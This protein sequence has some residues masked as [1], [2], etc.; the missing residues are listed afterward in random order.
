MKSFKY[1]LLLLFSTVWLLSA[2]TSHY[3]LSEGIKRFYLHS[4]NSIGFACTGD[5][6]NCGI[7][8]VLSDT[9]I[10]DKSY[11][12]VKWEWQHIHNEEY[13]F[14]TEKNYFRIDQGI[15]YRYS[16][17][18]DEFVQD[19]NFSK[20]DSLAK[21]FN[22]IEWQTG[23]PPEI[24]VYDTLATFSDGSTHRVLW[25]DNDSIFIPNHG[26]LNEQLPTCKGF[27]DSVLVISDNN[28]ILPTG[29]TEYYSPSHP[30]YFIDS[31]GVVYSEWNHRQMAL[32]GISYP[33]G[34]LFG[35]KI[36]FITS[37]DHGKIAVEFSLKQNF[38]NPFNPSTN[39]EFEM[40]RAGIVELIVYDV[41]GKKVANLLKEQKNTGKYSVVFN[42]TNLVSGVYYYKLKTSNFVEVRKM[43]LM[44]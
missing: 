34:R 13:K 2:G 6:F 22:H 33:D 4:C 16:N 1:I 14:V 12:M 38:P 44:K 27:V 32:V 23:D 29:S 24:I 37:I 9:T 15:L 36:N 8:T 30:F 40:N 42:A 7:E 35:R 39:I 28:W 5:F 20:G 18:N 31:I 26:Y 3:D 21:F 25:A 17:S 11:Q 41:Q 43:L 19:Y 10:N